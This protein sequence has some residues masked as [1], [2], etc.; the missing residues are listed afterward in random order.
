MLQFI[1]IEEELIA[2]LRP[3]GEVEGKRGRDGERITAECTRQGAGLLP[4]D[5]D[6]FRRKNSFLWIGGNL[7]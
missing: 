4:F 1:H 3:K 5:V 6:H 7:Y 2:K